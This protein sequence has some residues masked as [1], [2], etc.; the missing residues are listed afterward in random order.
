MHPNTIHFLCFSL[1][2]IIISK[3]E[4]KS[5]QRLIGRTFYKE[6][7]DVNNLRGW[8]MLKYLIIFVNHI[9]PRT[10]IHTAFMVFSPLFCVT[11]DFDF[12]ILTIYFY[13]C[14]NVFFRLFSLQFYFSNTLFFIS[15]SSINHL[16]CLFREQLV[17]KSSLFATEMARSQN[18]SGAFK[19]N[20][21]AFLSTILRKRKILYP[22]FYRNPPSFFISSLIF[23]QTHPI[24]IFYLISTIM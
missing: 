21:V 23:Q 15:Q 3:L 2:I 4:S 17:L 5:G 10:I 13:Y 22:S 8:N 9:S 24:F 16:N 6:T 14:S 1:I 12:C 7:N 18:Q 20:N 19:F 11:L